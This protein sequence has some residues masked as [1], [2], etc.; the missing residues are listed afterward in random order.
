[1]L[2]HNGAGLL[3]TLDPVPVSPSGTEIHVEHFTPPLD[4]VEESRHLGRLVFLEI[5]AFVV[6]HFDRVQAV[7]FAFS[8]PAALLVRSSQQAADRAEIMH[9]IGVE[10]VQVAPKPA[11]S[12]GHFV[13]TGNWLYSERNLAALNEVLDELRAMYRDGR[14]I[15]S[16][17]KGVAAV[18]TRLASRWR[19]R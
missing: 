9:R 4:D 10:N 11:A 7:S 12:P 5:C 6:E 15:G 17:P 19:R 14:P 8:R 13:V 16:D 2:V 18:L 1:M 3:C